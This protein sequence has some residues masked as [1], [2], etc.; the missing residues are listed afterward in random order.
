MII[1]IYNYYIEMLPDSF[2]KDGGSNNQKLLSINYDA[3]AELSGDIASVYAML[4]LNTASGKTL[5]LYGDMLDQTR[6]SLN[7]VQYRT[8]L[9]GIIAKNL[10]KGDYASV[11]EAVSLIFNCD[12]SE[13]SFEELKNRICTVY[14]RKLPYAVIVKSGFTAKQAIDIIDMVL[15]VTVR[16]DAD[17]LEGT[18]EFGTVEHEKDELKGFGNIE[19]TI[20]GFFGALFGFDDEI[21][22]PI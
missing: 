8:L 4:D 14:A 3:L 7:D 15:P 1:L 11:I 18:F 19:Q 9:R 10:C 21:G 5:D 22:L 13:I 16:L 17:N 12:K 2:A 20:G 6:G